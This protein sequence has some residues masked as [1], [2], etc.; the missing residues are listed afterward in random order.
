MLKPSFISL[1][2]IQ[3]LMRKVLV[4]VNVHF[5]KFGQKRSIDKIEHCGN[6]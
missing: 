4:L 6:C 1:G 3:V 5:F 2:A